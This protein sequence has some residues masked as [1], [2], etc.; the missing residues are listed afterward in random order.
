ME[1]QKKFRNRVPRLYWQNYLFTPKGS[2]FN[3]AEI[4]RRGHQYVLPSSGRSRISKYR[5]FHRK[6]QTICILMQRKYYLEFDTA[7]ERKR[8]DAKARR[9]IPIIFHK[10]A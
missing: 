1:K 5:K 2:A 8:M 7:I 3:S 4:S 6:A 9:F 10:F